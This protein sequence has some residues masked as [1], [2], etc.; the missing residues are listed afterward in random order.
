MYHDDFL[1]DSDDEDFDPNDPDRGVIVARRGGC[2]QLSRRSVRPRYARDLY[3]T[4]IVLNPEELPEN[5]VNVAYASMSLI[6]ISRGQYCRVFMGSILHAL[7]P[8][9][10][11]KIHALIAGCH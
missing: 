2:R 11:R 3:W 8:G 9:S 1:S 7:T 6:K 10:G 5:T 4:C